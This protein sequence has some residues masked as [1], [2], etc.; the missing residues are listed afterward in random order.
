MQLRVPLCRPT[1]EDDEVAAVVE[2]LRSGWLASGPKTAGFEEAFGQY[3]GAP[4]AIAV[5]SGTAGLHLVLA[6]LGIGPGDEVITPSMTWPATANVVELLGA[7]AVFADVLPGTLLLDCADVARRITSRTRAVIP[8]HY[9]GAPVDLEGLRGVLRGRSITVVHDAAH[10]VGTRHRGELIGGGAEPAVFSFHPIKNITTGEGGMVTLAD[11]RLAERVRLLRFHGITKDA[12]SR[13]HS[14]GAGRYEVLEPGWKYAMS[15]LHAALGLVQLTK[16]DRFNARRQQL[17]D[18]YDLLLRGLDTIRLPESPPYPHTHAWHLYVVRLEQSLLGIDRDGF[19]AELGE[20][21]IGTGLHF[22]PV[23]L[24]QHYRRDGRNSPGDLPVT[25]AAG[26]TVL[27]L[28]LYPDM[29]DEE[30]DRVVAAVRTVAEAHRVR[31]GEG[32]R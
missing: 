18:R 7:R 2:V 31:T 17:A 1:I 20:L 26:E 8:V 21:G 9:A 10:A 23:H 5:E 12:W 25:E 29:T 14:S 4:H 15:D 30:Q 3:V 28:P 13:H 24:H 6:A 27:S 22:T 19:M 11:D 16:L 32:V